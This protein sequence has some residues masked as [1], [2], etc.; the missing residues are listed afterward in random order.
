MVDPVI[1]VDGHTY[2]R[3]AIEKWFVGHRTR[4]RQVGGREGGKRNGTRR[5]SV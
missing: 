2:E 4:Y 5:E 3:H 1:C